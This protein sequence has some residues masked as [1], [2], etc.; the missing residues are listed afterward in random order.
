[1]REI[2][3]SVTTPAA[4]EVVTGYLA[5]FTDARIWHPGARDCVRLDSGAPEVGARWLVRLR[6]FDLHYTLIRRGR[7]R[8]T[9]TARRPGLTV[10]LDHVCTELDHGTEIHTAVQWHGPLSWPAGPALARLAGRLETALNLI[11]TTTGEH[12]AAP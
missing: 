11:P 7:H 3:H 9:F 5:G 2:T 8:I 4:L 12:H 6:A 1:M 10:L